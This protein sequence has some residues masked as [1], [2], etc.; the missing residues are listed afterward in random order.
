VLKLDIESDEVQNVL[1][2]YENKAIMAKSA[3][4]ASQISVMRAQETV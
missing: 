3:E 2:T 1:D 4:L